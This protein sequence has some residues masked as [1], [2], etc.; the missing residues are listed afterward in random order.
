MHRTTAARLATTGRHSPEG[1][2]HACVS[3]STDEA[4]GQRPRAS[5]GLTDGYSKIAMFVWSRGPRG[6]RYVKFYWWP[7]LLSIGISLL[8]TWLVNQ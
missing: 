3:P 1:N 7:L 6:P 8:V 2:A 5:S 4:R